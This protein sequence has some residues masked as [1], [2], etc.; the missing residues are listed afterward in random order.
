VELR[1]LVGLVLEVSIFL[2]VFGSGLQTT[3]GDLAAPFRRP[4]ELATSLVAMFGVMPMV[5]VTLSLLFHLHPAVEIALVALSVSPMP[6]LLPNRE[7][8]AGGRMSYGIGLMV[9]AAVMS[10]LFIPVPSWSADA[11]FNTRCSSSRAARRPNVMPFP[12]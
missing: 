8:K 7:V 11:C 4:G 9:V 12:P 6:L 2:T 5:G 10:I 1:Q 3:R